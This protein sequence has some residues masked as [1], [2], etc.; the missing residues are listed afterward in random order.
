MSYNCKTP[1]NS[2]HTPPSSPTAGTAKKGARSENAFV[3]RQ[4]LTQLHPV[5]ETGIEQKTVEEC[6]TK[7]EH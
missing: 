7:S 1:V 3:R 5:R 6:K 2:M 4:Q